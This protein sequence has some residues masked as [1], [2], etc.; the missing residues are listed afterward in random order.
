[1]VNK[2]I[3]KFGKIDILVNNAG[4]LLHI[5]DPTK[6]SITAI[7]ENEWDKLVEINL[8]VLFM[9]Q[10]NSTYMKEKRYGKIINTSSIGAIHPRQLLPITMPLKRVF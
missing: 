7:P 8:K 1:M 3:S 4:T 9:F 10:G 5:A 6:R 2:V